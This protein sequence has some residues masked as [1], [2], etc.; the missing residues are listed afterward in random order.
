M[1]TQLINKLVSGIVIMN[2][3]SSS[4]PN[5]LAREVNLAKE[6]VVYGL[7]NYDGSLNDAYIV[8]I[9][10]QEGD[11]TDYG[12][13]T[14]VR[15]MTSETELKL[16]E[17]KVD[18]T[19]GKDKLYYEGKLNNQQLPWAISIKYLLNQ[20]E[21][22][23]QDLV[24]QSGDLEIQLRIKENEQV[25]PFF[26]NN[27]GLQATLVFDTEKVKA[28]Q[29]EEATI[30]NVGKNKQLTYTVLPK[31]GANFSIKAKVENF[32][33]E[34]IA[35]NGININ[36]GFD[37]E[38]ANLLEKIEELQSGV[39]QIDEG[40]GELKDG[41]LQLS[42]GSGQ[43]ASGSQ[44]LEEGAVRV[45][46]GIVTLKKGIEQMHAGLV[47]LDSHSEELR[48]GS[49]QFK[50]L[51]NASND[52][53]SLLAE[54]L[55]KLQ[56]LNQAS[57]EMQAGIGELNS[58]ITQLNQSVGYQQYTAALGQNG[59]DMQQLQAGN[60]NG[61]QAVNNL[62]LSLSS[63]A[64]QIR[65]SEIEN[66]EELAAQLDQVIAQTQAANLEQVLAANN[67]MIDATAQYLETVSSSTMQLQA[68]SQELTTAY[69]DFH[70]AIQAM[71]STSDELV[72]EL[73]KLSSGV[74]DLAV[75]Y[76]QFDQG[77]EDYTGSLGKLV[78]SHQAILNGIR[79]LSEG[80]A[81]LVEGS[82]SLDANL[83]RLV[84]ASNDLYEG[85]DKLKQ[86]SN[87]FKNKTAGLDQEVEQEIDAT[88]SELTGNANQPISYASS[89][90]GKI[91]SVQFVL[92]TEKIQADKEEPELERE[93]SQPSVWEKIKDLFQKKE[94]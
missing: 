35:I 80:S 56:Q 72:A 32:E 82:S 25:D 47:E 76:T 44:R 28:I 52:Q 64:S 70:A 93:E 48:Q 31:Q 60:N 59:L 15:N 91:K 73:P 89:K 34:P 9:F 3:L 11:I 53:L 67:A 58:G 26:F 10:D 5:V 45:N 39:K 17:G 57:I 81:S 29:A 41:A 79:S 63:V 68:G 4:L 50:A 51:I 55:G 1:K 7:L 90:N 92:K 40:A 61:M 37:L 22:S 6:E 43:L 36:L 62:N 12:D 18:F 88:L 49:D 86:G 13:Y 78:S 23:A 77:L 87:K 24:G 27:Y 21:V 14:E 85:S 84:N 20:Q 65:A 38:D 94:D 71:V 54:K 74:E 69:S 66:K 46:N 16:K 75:K 30:A 83:N 42:E 8:N 19:N 2:I 33:M